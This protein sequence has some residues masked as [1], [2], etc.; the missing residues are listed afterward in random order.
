[1]LFHLCR[2]DVTPLHLASS[3][4]NSHISELLV[5]WGADIDAQESWGQ[6][7]LAIATLRGH[8]T[9]MDALLRLGAD[10]E[11]KDHHHRQTPLH[12]A[13]SSCN[14]ESVLVLLDASCDV[15][16]VNGEGRSAL[17][18]AMSNRFYRG[19]PLLIEYGARLNDADRMI[20]PEA[21]Q[22]YIDKQSGAGG[23]IAHYNGT[24]VNP[25][26]TK[27]PVNPL[28]A[29]TPVNPLPTNDA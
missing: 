19:V 5:Q 18:V 12:I 1:M 17:G 15:H 10:T 29:K 26:P 23:S 4:G 2:F 11:L 9:C 22:D 6:T 16:S 13:C 7:P 25:L 21:L 24:P 14:E 20:I 28:Q 3:S 27:T 8:A